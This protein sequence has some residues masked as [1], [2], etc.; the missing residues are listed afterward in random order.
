VPD[1]EAHL[2]SQEVVSAQEEALDDAYCEALYA[3]YLSSKDADDN[4]ILHFDTL[5]GQ[6]GIM[7]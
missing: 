5:L 2:P 7:F 3:A 6:L 4:E 1:R